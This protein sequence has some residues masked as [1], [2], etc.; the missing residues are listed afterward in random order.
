MKKTVCITG[1]ARRVG[2]ELALRFSRSGFAV[3][4]H[5]RNSSEEADKLQSRIRSGGGRCELFPAELTNPAA[6]E[7]LIRA[8]LARMGGLELLINSAATF[9]RKPLA[10][11]EPAFLEA[12]FRLNLFAPFELIRQYAK[13][14]GA[15]CII[16]ILD[17]KIAKQSREYPVYTL[18]KKALAE[19]T[20]TVALEFAPEFRIN[21][22]A[23]GVLLEEAGNPQPLPAL[24]STPLKKRC[25]LDD[26][27][28]TILHLYNNASITGQIIFTDGGKHL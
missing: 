26:F 4:L 6:P 27:F 22:V 7:Q 5:Y 14:A 28:Q 8:V 10:E 13:Q 25:S 24:E 11:T 19:L 3:A 17:T 18:T 12:L 1:A 20:R 15:G 21:G 2:A 9:V 16:N 23:P